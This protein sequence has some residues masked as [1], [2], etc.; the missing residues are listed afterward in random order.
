VLNSSD[1]D[2]T[3]L[4][5]G[6]VAGD[7]THANADS[8]VVAM[9]STTAAPA[10]TTGPAPDA[11]TLGASLAALVHGASTHASASAPVQSELHAPVGT[12]AWSDE[13]GTQLTW[14][15]HRG[16][17][18]ASLKLSPADLGPIE[19]RIAVHDSQASVWFGA[20][21]PDTRAALEQ[22]LP[23]LRELFASQGLALSDTGVFRE[24]PRQQPQAAPPTGIARTTREVDASRVTAVAHSTRLGLVDL[25]A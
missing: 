5:S 2:L 24:A 20:A 23:R 21:H 11:S 8:A 17:E 22:A 19:V 18:S 12:A 4:F 15:A 9:P 16:T 10:V 7:A 3:R 6:T 25:Y 14:M 1:L 13:L